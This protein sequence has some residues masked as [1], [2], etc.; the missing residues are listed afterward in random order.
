M[1]RITRLTIGALLTVAVLS[2]AATAQAEI[3]QP[4]PSVS[5]VGADD[6]GLSSGSAGLQK[7]V[8]CTIIKLVLMNQG[9]E[10]CR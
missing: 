4:I 5:L 2:P 3:P 10:F 9:P 7:Q 6:S 8:V 1:T